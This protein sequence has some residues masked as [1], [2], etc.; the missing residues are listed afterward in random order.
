M[1]FWFEYLREA[2]NRCSTRS[3]RSTRSRYIGHVI[4]IQGMKQMRATSIRRFLSRSIETSLNSMNGLGCSHGSTGSRLTRAF[5]LKEASGLH[6][7]CREHQVPADALRERTQMKVAIDRAL[8][9]LP[10]RQRMTFILRH[11]EGYTF[12]GIGRSWKLARVLQRLIITTQ[13]GNYGHT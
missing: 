4:N 8:E 9:R 5:R 13:C 7:L 11:Y 6:C 2:K 1:R 12:G 10:E 3:L